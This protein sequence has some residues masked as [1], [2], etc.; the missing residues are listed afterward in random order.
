MTTSAAEGASKLYALLYGSPK[1]PES[2][3]KPVPPSKPIRDRKHPK[4]KPDPKAA[5]RFALSRQRKTE[6]DSP[7]LNGRGIKT[8]WVCQNCGP[9]DVN[10]FRHDNKKY[11]LKCLSNMGMDRYWEQR[12]R[13][14]ER[15]ARLA[16]I[17][18]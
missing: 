2:V 13:D 7:Y 3:P 11:C 14:M 16:K 18:T 9:L 1:E 10:K 15:A 4:R 5:H 6:G 17:K 8:Q 12:K